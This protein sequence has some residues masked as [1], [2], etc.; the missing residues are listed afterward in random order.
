MQ[1]LFES[2]ETNLSPRD[3]RGDFDFLFGKWRVAHRRLRERLVDNTDWETF[4]GLIECRPIIGGIGNV[5]DNWIELPAGTYR[6]ASIRLFNPV[7]RLWSI[8]W[9]DERA[10]Q[11]DVPVTG[12]FEA[13]A[14][15]FF[16]DDTYQ[17]RDI[18]VRFTWSDI[19]ASS[20]RWA[21]AFSVDSGASWET[22]W[23]MDFAR[24]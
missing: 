20:A 24:T 3:G 10:G 11:L 1:R 7:T 4:D 17:G 5:D 2:A 19:T 9:A 14:G 18:R 21:Q 8:W 23:V 16:A 6:A 22:N 13:G 15:T 12:R